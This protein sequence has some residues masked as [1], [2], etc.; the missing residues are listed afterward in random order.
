MNVHVV[1]KRRRRSPLAPLFGLILLVAVVGGAY[2]A[3]PAIANWLENASLTVGAGWQ[4]LPVTFPVEWP[5]VVSRLVIT[6]VVT[7]VAFT[8]LMP[9]LFLFTRAPGDEFD[10]NVA[11]LRAAK[12]RQKKR[13]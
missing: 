3:S 1:E 6:G 4:L 2:L 9:L 11:D 5:E 7:L 10:V 13:R 8:I 12:Q